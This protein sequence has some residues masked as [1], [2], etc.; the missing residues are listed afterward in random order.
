VLQL[1]GP[2]HVLFGSDYPFAP[3]L[4]VSREVADRDERDILDDETRRKVARANAEVLFPRLAQV[5]P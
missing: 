5:F 1:A 2:S 3:A 4:A